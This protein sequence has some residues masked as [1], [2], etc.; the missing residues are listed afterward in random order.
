[1]QTNDVIISLRCSLCSGLMV[2]SHVSLCSVAKRCSNFYTTVLHN[3][4]CVLQVKSPPNRC[5]WVETHNMCH[6]CAVWGFWRCHPSGKA[7]TLQSFSVH[8]THARLTSQPDPSSLSSLSGP[9]C[10]LTCASPA[11]PTLYCHGCQ[12]T[13]RNRFHMPRYLFS[14]PC[15][16]IKAVKFLI[17]TFWLF[18]VDTPGSRLR[19]ST[20]HWFNSLRKLIHVSLQLDCLCRDGCIT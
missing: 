20:L 19:P 8:P 14:P 7:H 10:L 16:V 17:C 5:S 6:W 9:W 18:H 12:H 11:L 15:V 1:M 3:V 4:S 2:A 13:L